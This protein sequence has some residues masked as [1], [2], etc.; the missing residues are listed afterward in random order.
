MAERSV[1]SR[2]LASS[3]F[4]PA[5]AVA[6]TSV[7]LI[8]LFT[9][10]ELTNS[11]RAP[12]LVIVI[13]ATVAV[14]RSHPVAAA[15][16]QAAAFLATPNFDDNF[17][18]DSGAIVASI[19]AYSCGAHAA[20]RSGLV[21]VGALAACMQ[22]GMG[23]SEF[24]NFEVYFGTLGP[25]W[26]GVQV[27]RRRLLV[28]EL[29][30]RT[31]QLES[32]QDAFARLSVRRERARIARE[33]H[34]IVAHHLAV[35]VVQAGAG[36]MAPAEQGDRNAER[37]ATVRQSGAHALAEM[38]RLVDILE[39][40]RGNGGAPGKLRVLLDEAAAGGVEVGFTP[41]PSGVRLPTEVEDVAYRVVREGLTNAI[42]HAPGAAVQVRLATHGDELEIE[43]RDAGAT[44]AS[45]LAATGSGLG[46]AG[47]RERVESLGGSLEAGPGAGGGWRLA[48]RLPMAVHLR[49]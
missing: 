30:E 2:A 47:M 1:A 11:L 24:P 21:A 22:V 15:G 10:P 23:F 26:V 38:A 35:M 6:L 18:P 27:R 41:L 37:F 12:I 28:S 33:L 14:R 46:L 19:V 43:V 36:R 48:V 45:G 40:D 49:V 9:S 3:W 34:D 25:W 20:Q 44:R 29:A 42:K 31:A 32:E 7:A 4:D 16:V 17:L 5:L 8:E 13:G 39:A